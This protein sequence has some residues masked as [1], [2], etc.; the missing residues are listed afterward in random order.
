MEKAEMNSNNSKEKWRNSL[1][2]KR[3]NSITKVLWKKY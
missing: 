1:K 3:E 2:E